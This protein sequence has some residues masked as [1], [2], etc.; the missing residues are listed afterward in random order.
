MIENGFDFNK[1]FKY[2]IPYLK[3]SEIEVLLEKL[4]ERQKRSEVS[5]SFP[6]VENSSE[7][8]STINSIISNIDNILETKSKKSFTTEKYYRYVRKLIY[9]AV[10]QKYGSSILLE[11]NKDETMTIS[12]G[13][14]AD[15][16][17]NIQ[18]ENYLKEKNKI[19]DEAGF[20]KVVRLII[21]SVSVLVRICKNYTMLTF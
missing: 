3:E 5:E 19:L 14:C 21:D 11:T 10:Q 7:H 12:V 8:T 16:I 4:E 6:K 17:K 2:G 1:V 15:E 18:K 13:F 9:N 20:C